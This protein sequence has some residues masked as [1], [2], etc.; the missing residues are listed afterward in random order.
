[1]GRRPDIG[2]AVERVERDPGRRSAPFELRVTV[3]PVAGARHWVVSPTHIVI[4]RKLYVD[5]KQVAKWL[6]PVV[7]SLA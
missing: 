7:R 6:F 5:T 2:S 3:L 4:S 1:M